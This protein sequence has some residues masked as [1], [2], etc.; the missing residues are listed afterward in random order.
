MTTLFGKLS[1]CTGL[2]WSGFGCR[3]YDRFQNL[4]VAVAIITIAPTVIS[5]DRSI[6]CTA[7]PC[8]QKDFSSVF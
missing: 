7:S 3:R 4:T 5:Y 6:I 2:P 1:S 8:K